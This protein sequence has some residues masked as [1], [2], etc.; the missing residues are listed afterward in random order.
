MLSLALFVTI[1]PSAM[2]QQTPTEPSSKSK[3]DLAENKTAVTVQ[4]P[5]QIEFLET[6]I[7]FESDGSSRKEVHA[8]V[9]INTELGVR[10][11]ARLNFDYNRAFET[12][13]IP[14]A[15]IT[16]AGGGRADILPS[17]ISDSTNP[18]VGDASAYQDVRRKTVRILGLQPT[19]QLEY[20]V[21]TSTA[22]APLAPDFYLFHTFA[23]DAIVT[24][25]IFELDLPASR[26]LQLRINP[27]TPPAS[28]DKSAS[29]TGA[30]TIYRWGRTETEAPPAVDKTRP[31]ISSEPDVALTT[32]KSWKQL[33]SRLAQI[34]APGDE[35]APGVVKKFADLTATTKTPEEKVEALYDFVSLKI[36]TLDLPLGSNGFRARA[37]VDILSAGYATP[38]DKMVLLA[39]LL[40]A[41]KLPPIVAL[42]GQPDVAE[43]LLPRPSVFTHALIWT[44]KEGPGFWLDP[45]IEVAPFRMVA[46]N[47]RGKPAFLLLSET[48]NAG[49]SRW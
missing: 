18:A 15:R 49:L 26:D 20:R 47:L 45:S 27:E 44:G 35:I 25:E 11:F 17:A 13:D 46:S 41:A 39:A 28:Q 34:F 33:S 12:V 10:Q 31:A 16:H 9:R 40:R 36:A 2:A 5:A 6:H 48:E 24:Q 21:I 7:R 32:F 3:P 42:A 43:T 37:P 14:L 29:G 8:R 23:K 19:D 38:E 1:L 22:H 30:R 4:T